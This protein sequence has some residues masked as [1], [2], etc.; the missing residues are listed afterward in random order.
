VEQCAGLAP[1]VMLSPP[2]PEPPDG[3][4]WVHQ[5]KLDG[6]RCRAQVKLTRLRLWSWAGGE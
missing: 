3:L 4:G 2:A 6:F 1:Q 5:A